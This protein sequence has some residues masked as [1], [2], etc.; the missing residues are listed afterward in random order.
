MPEVRRMLGDVGSDAANALMKLIE[1]QSKATLAHWC[2]GF[3]ESKVLP[4]WLRRAPDDTRPRDAIALAK[5]VVSGKARQADVKQG[6]LPAS[7]AAAKEHADDPAAM[8]AA[9]AIGC[10]A[11]CFQT[12]THTLGF[13][14]YAAAAIAYDRV[15]THESDEVYAQIA[16]EVCAEYTAALRA[17]AVPNEPK[18][19][20]VSWSC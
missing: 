10:A 17:V 3:A 13:L 18:P 5:D 16:Q 8:A 9:R 19:A 4:I 6:L 15:G 2:I 7:Q 12:P 20:K 11:G 14:W 1:T